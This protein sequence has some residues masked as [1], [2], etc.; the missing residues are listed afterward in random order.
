MEQSR[1]VPLT[2]AESASLLWRLSADGNHDTC[3]TGSS[4]FLIE[5]NGDVE[6]KANSCRRRS[7]LRGSDRVDR[8]TFWTL[9][10]HFTQQELNTR[11]HR[12]K[13]LL[14]IALS[15]DHERQSCLRIEPRSSSFGHG[16]PRQPLSQ[17]VR[18]IETPACYIGGVINSLASSR[19]N[20]RPT[21]ERRPQ[22]HGSPNHRREH[23]LE[24]AFNPYD[25]VFMTDP[26]AVLARA[27]DEGTIFFSPIL[28]AW[29]VTR[30]DDVV[31]VLRGPG[32][33]SVPRRSSPSPNSCPPRSSICSVTRYPWR[34]P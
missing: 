19:S 10:R 8:R 25:T 17:E 34:A 29:I 5:S 9:E 12:S 33:C 11:I 14:T 2:H 1:R 24:S 4:D 32:A 30:Y 23:P 7:T 22:H 6:G 31:S 18:S 3:C 26:D 16:V 15:G 28:G 21:I 27:R 13:I 20:L